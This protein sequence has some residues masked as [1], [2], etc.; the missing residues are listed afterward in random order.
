MK[1]V[2]VMPVLA[3][4]LFAAACGGGTTEADPTPRVRFFNAT[5]GMT[6][7][8]GFTTNG[9]FVTALAFGQASQSCT[10]LDEGSTSFG[11]GAANS[12]GTGLSGAAISTLNNQT[13]KAGGNYTMVATGSAASPQLYLLDNNSSA[14]VS[15]KEAAV[16]FV[17]LAPGPAT[18]PNIFYVFTSWP[19]VQ[20]GALFEASLLVGSPS[21]FRAVASGTTSFTTIIGHQ[22]E[23]VNTNP[24]TL[25]AGS[26]NTIV[27]VPNPSGGHQLIN[28]PRC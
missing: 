26:V 7:S 17:N 15:S 9:Q 10:T 19:P 13:I 18:L 16:R 20:D 2:S 27:I 3:A 11:F 21:P 12:G 22:I 24:V 5:T 8:G 4:L 14:S 28:V 25:Q 6:G 23:T 1:T